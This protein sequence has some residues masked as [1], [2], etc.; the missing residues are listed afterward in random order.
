M[1][2]GHEW[3]A[4][5]KKKEHIQIHLLV[6]ASGICA[7]PIGAAWS[8]VTLLHTQYTCLVVIIGAFESVSSTQQTNQINEIPRGFIF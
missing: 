8:F 7:G 3:N 5:V 6:H 4:R 1:K 2:S